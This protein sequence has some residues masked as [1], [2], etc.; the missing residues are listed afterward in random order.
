MELSLVIVISILFS[1]F[2]SGMEMAF[3]SANKMRIELER[4]KKSF[5]SGVIQVFIH[6]PGQ[7]ITTMLV[8]NN[9]AL[10]VYGITMASAMEPFISRQIPNEVSVFIVQTIFATLI[11]L[12]TAEFIPKTLFRI[13]PNLALEVFA[14]PVFFFYVLFYPITRFTIGLS[15][16]ILRLV[17]KAKIPDNS[18]QSIFNKVDLDHF[19]K[20]SQIILPEDSKIGNE[21]RIFQ[22]ALDFGKVKLRECMIPRPEIV[23]FEVSIPIREIRKEFIDSGYS[24]IL[25]YKNNIDNIIG[26]IN[27]KDLFR[28]PKTIRSLLTP[29]II[30]PE[31]MPAN[32][33]LSQFIKEK[34]NIAIVVDEFGG[35]AGMLTIE[36]LIEEIFGEIEDEHDVPELE[37]KQVGEKEF[38]F[39]G[40]LEI[41]YLNEKYKLNIPKTEE[42]E[43]LAGFI[44]HHY[45]SIPK[46]NHRIIIPPFA[47]KILKVKRNRVDLVNLQLS[48]DS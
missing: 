33:L 16:I 28:K 17:F 19:V 46:I 12:L 32:K 4:K 22:N 31:T 15:N 40:R 1:A 24:R 27:S 3:V 41:D 7:Y 21:I 44:L 14:F 39:S 13:K 11:I 2:F 34:K 43:T 42:Y 37:E 45:E 9:I 20:E 48:D 47:F 30:V 6:N 8:G 23:A 10:V 25:I 26:Y 35:T 18:N 5:A 36:D 29:I 38:V